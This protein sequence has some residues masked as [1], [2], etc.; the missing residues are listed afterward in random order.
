MRD[1]HRMKEKYEV[2]LD[3]RQ[4]VSMTVGGLVVVA[5]VFVLGVVVGK[6]LAVDDTSAAAPDLLSALDQ[7]K[8]VM[9]SMQKDASLTFQDELTKKP[10]PIVDAKPIEAPKPVVVAEVAPPKPFELPVVTPK[11]PEPKPTEAPRVEAV[12]TRI[13]E[14]AGALRDA[15]ARV[16]KPEPKPETSPDGNFTLQLSAFQDKAE[17]DRFAATLR[18]KGYAPFIVEAVLPAKGTWYRVRMGRFPTRD[19]AGRYLA[20]FKR[21]TSIDAIVTGTN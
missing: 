2:S 11:P 4:I 16:Q 6:K 3:N 9:D 1:A 17:A 20:D 21:E 12:A 10:E 19:A 14:D 15:I 5:A 7:R 8:A 13:N 18:D